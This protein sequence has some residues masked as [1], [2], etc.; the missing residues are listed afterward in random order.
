[1]GCP[2]RSQAWVR[3]R[4]WGRE[5]GSGGRGGGERA[6]VRIGARE[7]GRGAAREG[8][9]GGR[10]ERDGGGR[11]PRR[12]P[13]ARSR[14]LRLLRVRSARPRRDGLARGLPLLLPRPAAPPP[15]RAPPA[16]EWPR[17]AGREGGGLC[18]TAGRA[19]PGAGARGRGA[20]GARGGAGSGAG[21]PGLG[22]GVG[23]RASR[24]SWRPGK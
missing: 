21:A 23:D 24:G 11:E 19:V 22:L 20:A 15:R 3:R 10:G 2:L 7:G 9:E 5:A 1:M 12:A 6:D 18:V 4:R 8:G 16:G 17:Y 14:L 13:R